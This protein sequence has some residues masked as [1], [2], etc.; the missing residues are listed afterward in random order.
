LQED[1]LRDLERLIGAHS[2]QWF[3]FQP[4]VR[5]ESAL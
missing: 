5:T 2:D 4:I 3:H 1:C